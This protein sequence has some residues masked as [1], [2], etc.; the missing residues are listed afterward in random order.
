MEDEAPVSDEAVLAW[1][2]L[3]RSRNRRGKTNHTTQ[4]LAEAM[5]CKWR[6]AKA[7]LDEL[8][9]SGYL[10]YDQYGHPEFTDVGAPGDDPFQSFVPALTRA[11]VPSSP[12]ARAGV[13]AGVPGRALAGQLPSQQLEASSTVVIP[14][15]I[16]H[17]AAGAF[18]AKKHPG[19]VHGPESLVIYNLA[20]LFAYQ[21][22]KQ[23][24]G[25]SPHPTNEKA[26]RG[27][28]RTWV[29]VDKIP[30]TTVYDMIQLFVSK[31]QFIRKGVPAWKS[32]IVSRQR[33][34]FIVQ[35]QQGNQT[36]ETDWVRKK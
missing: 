30:P 12:R 13:P 17:N 27:Q 31:P 26:I 34:L 33:L 14:N 29:V 15:G 24:K 16:T 23:F 11:G 6:D 1:W 22:R 35:E 8:Q 32:F 7:F 5:K 36:A 3:Y 2:T 28:I 21:V 20:N 10:K 4:T 18:P 9:D 25:M 19:W